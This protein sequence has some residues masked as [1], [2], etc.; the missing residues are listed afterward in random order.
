MSIKKFVLLALK[1]NL[2][3]F[4][5]ADLF[6]VVSISMFY[7]LDDPKDFVKTISSCLSKDG[8]WALELSYLPL[9]LKQLSYDQLC[10]E[11]VGYYNLV[12]LKNIFLKFDLCIFEVSLNDMNGGSIYLK[13]CHKEALSKYNN[14]KNQ[15]LIKKLL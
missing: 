12:D 11:H 10:H 2:S 1:F 4:N 5:L 15:D 13:V 7:D 3:K 8:V 6:L 14:P 9:F